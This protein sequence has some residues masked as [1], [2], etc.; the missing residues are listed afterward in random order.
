MVKNKNLKLSIILGVLIMVTLIQ[1]LRDRGGDRLDIDPNQFTIADTAAIGKVSIRI[2]DTEMVLTKEDSFWKLG[3]DKKA[4]EYYISL[5]KAV[6]SSVEVQRPLS[7]QEL[8][9]EDVLS[10][11]A[12]VSIETING[13]VLEFIAGGNEIQ[14]Q[15]YFK[16]KSSGE[17]YLVNIPGYR[18]FVS[19]IFLLTEKEWED[20]TL[21]E[22]SWTSLQKLEVKYPS[23]PDQSFSIKQNNGFPQ[24]MELSAVDTTRMMDYLSIFAGLKA[25]Y[26]LEPVDYD[27]IIGT[28]PQLII[29]IEDLNS[30]KNNQL[31][32]YYLQPGSTVQVGL[33]KNGQIIGFDYRNV[34]FI[35]RPLAYFRA[36]N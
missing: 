35:A 10:N 9:R 24:I 27:S 8:I 17:V 32:L 30:D 12:E 34:R 36:K 22:T 25:N 16:D 14:T 4:D 28:E 21:F 2:K 23:N 11:T 1:L 19:G 31:Q 13:K 20:K 6:I 5:L 29:N 18:S 33:M 3:E 7:S 15:S 26:F